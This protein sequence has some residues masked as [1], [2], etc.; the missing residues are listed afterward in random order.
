VL[1]NLRREDR[2]LSGTMT[3]RIN[4]RHPLHGDKPSNETEAPCTDLLRNSRLFAGL[5]D[6]QL[7]AVGLL[8]QK[9]HCP[10]G[11]IL[12][13]EGDRVA[14]VL[15]VLKGEVAV[16]IKPF[17]DF[18]LRPRA[19]QVEK[20]GRGGVIGCCALVRGRMKMT[21]RCT[22][23]TEIATI[24]ADE[25]E[26]WLAA[27]PDTGLIVMKNALKMATDRLVLARQQLIAQFGLSGMYETYRNY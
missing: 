19:V 17:Q 4:Q 1:N 7:A 23:D 10:K 20:I 25:L 16:E 8:C 5:S 26:A 18:H 13:S 6:R 15:V 9:I 21:A 2:M 22:E 12:V 11:R 24:S 3:T 27:H 14:K